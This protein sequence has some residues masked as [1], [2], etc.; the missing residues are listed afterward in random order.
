MFKVPVKLDS[1]EKRKKGAGV[2][3]VLAGLFL[4]FKLNEVLS[5]ENNYIFLSVLII[6]ISISSIAYGMVRRKIDPATKY[7]SMVRLLQ[8]I[9]FLS[10]GF[11]LLNINSA[12]SIAYF[13]W[14]AVTLVILFVERK[15]F[16]YT[17]LQIAADGIHVPGFFSTHL[18]P[19]NVVDSLI[20]R[21]DYLTIFRTNKKFVQLELTQQVETGEIEKIN[22]FSKNQIEKNKLS[23]S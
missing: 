5:A 10:V 18:I 19:W 22:E 8:F 13:A 11:F 23:T 14:A 12:H 1:I 17:D 3:H 9:G 15:V 16:N 6:L 20:L 4:A 21:P 7:N 2:L